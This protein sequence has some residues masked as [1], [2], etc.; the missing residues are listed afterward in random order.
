MKN[1]AV[2]GILFALCLGITG[3]GGT[4][5]AVDNG[6]AE[7]AS[8]AARNLWD[9]IDPEKYVTLGQYK[10]LEVTRLSTD[11]SKDDIEAELADSIESFAE[12][13][14]VT[15]RNDVR[16]GDIVNIDFV[17]KR[18]G[19]AFEGGS[20]KGFDLTIGSGMFIPGF[21]EGLIGKKV[22]EQT[23][24]NLTFP[25]YYPNDESLQGQPVVFEVSVNSI[26]AMPDI[27]D[28]LVKKATNGEYDTIEAYRQSI[29]ENLEK[30]AVEYAD[31][32][33]YID[34]WKQ[35]V[36]SSE[37][38][39]EIPEELVNIK[40]EAIKKNAETLAQSYGL[41][42]E[43]YLSQAMGLSQEEFEEQAVEYAREGAKESLV[44]MALAKAE[45]I[46]LT[47]EEISK[48]TKEYVEMYNY[49]S[50][51]EFMESI[52]MEDFKEYILM[53]KVQEFLADQAVIKTE[54]GK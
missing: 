5:T 40:T 46:E 30:E 3:C 32:A 33:M 37:L 51:Q 1:R 4:A 8:S 2:T 36:D 25:D 35:V 38:K 45:N 28:E 48:A 19:V 11:I 21:E 41:D 50:V 27:T 31:S 23:E 52:N 24:L 6:T 34:L 44:L 12:A 54:D 43:S 53:S 20:S 13:V 10:G 16:E 7:A 42:W 22:G 9:S 47:P 18:D 39:G 49:G 15:D 14:E 29:R 26:K 17:G